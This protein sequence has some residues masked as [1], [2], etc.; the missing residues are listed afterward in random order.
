LLIPQ[1]HDLLYLCE[2]K[3]DRVELGSFRTWFEEELVDVEW[4]DMKHWHGRV[5]PQTL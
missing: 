2:R 5:E 3:D 4:W 1:S